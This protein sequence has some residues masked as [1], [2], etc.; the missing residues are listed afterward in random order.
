MSN[1]WRIFVIE[2]EESL[3]QS[4][5]NTLRKDG[6]IVQGALNDADTVRILWSEEYDVV[7][8][9][10]KTPGVGGLELMQWLRTFRPD[11][12]IIIVGDA[13]APLLRLQALEGGANGYLEKPLDLRLLREELRRLLQQTGFS[14][15]L[16][17]FDLLDV[18]QIMTMSR[19]NIAL[20]V[21]TGVEERGILRFHNGELI[22]AEYGMLRGEEAFFA[23]AA[24]KTGTVVQQPWDG[25][26]ISNV[27]LPLSRLIFQSLQYRSK[28]ANG[29]P[30]E[31][32]GQAADETALSV[33][34][35]IDDSPFMV[36]EDSPIPSM[37]P[38]QSR[39]T[40]ETISQEVAALSQETDANEAREWWEQS[41]QIPRV[42]EKKGNADPFVA[43]TFS[44]NTQTLSNGN[45]AGEPATAHQP[46]PSQRVDLPGWVTNQPTS[47]I[48][49]IHLSSLSNTG[50]IPVVPELKS[51][52]PEWQIP[53]HLSA[54]KTTEQLTSNNGVSS[55]TDSGVHRLSSSDWQSLKQASRPSNQAKLTK[56]LAESPLP[57]QANGVPAHL[58]R[59][60]SPLLDDDATGPQKSIRKNYNYSALVSA[61]Q[62][63]G[64]SIIGFVAAAIVSIDGRPIAQVA[65][66]DLD[67]SGICKHFST[68]LQS[69][70]L[71]L[72]G[73]AWGD[74]EDI[75]VT[76]VNR[77]ILIRI[78]CEE[79]KAFQVLITTRESDPVE[80][81]E[82]MANVEGVISTALR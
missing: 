67:I 15:D 42:E 60:N 68:L 8:C 2:G 53:S 34:D 56:D 52:S 64:Y 78:V 17:S 22:W 46:P 44:F 38:V 35:E 69:A 26:A 73:D 25:Q 33:L 39:P 36:L 57:Q 43:P 31:Y 10:L 61:L 18:I 82:V 81:L 28:Y 65:V 50:R 74:Y 76:T 14:A 71:S 19:K 16:D 55:S 3:N 59:E 54:L 37:S 66:D 12:R 48:P 4:I 11:T 21:N 9:D 41:R 58:L 1:V 51:S 75:V 32:E 47:S 70:L 30:S 7:V 6:Y 80:S 49:A 29:Q 40:R 63:L 23:L 24:H 79:K 20:L 13:D 45:G 5:V 72:E 77:H 27:T 62:T